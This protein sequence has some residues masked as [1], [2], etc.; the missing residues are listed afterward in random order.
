MPDEKKKAYGGMAV[1]EGV[2][3]R[4]PNHYSVACRTPNGKIFVR[5]EPIEKTWIGRQKWLLKPFLRGTFAL[6]DTMGLG[7]R[8]MRIAGDVQLDPRFQPEEGEMVHPERHKD[9]P[10]SRLQ[11]FYE[12]NQAVCDKAILGFTLVFSLVI[13]FLIF[14]VFP[15]FAG[16]Y[17]AALGKSMGIEP[18]G[19]ERGMFTT[20]LVET[21]KLVMFIG[22]VALIRRYPAIYEVFRFHGAEHQAINAM[23]EGVDLTPGNC[24]RQSRLHPR[25][26][27]NF[28]LIVFIVSFLLFPFVPRD[29]IVPG[30]SPSWL[31]AL[32][33][34]P[35]ELALLPIV[36]GI[37]YEVIRIAGKFKNE[38]WVN[39]VLWPG[40]KTQL[41]TTAEPDE[42]HA[43]VA[44]AALEAA[45]LAEEKGELTNS[46]DYVPACLRGSEEPGAP[47]DQVDRAAEKADLAHEA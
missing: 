42:R 3:M 6:L 41:I 46:D 23:E 19:N 10:P 12:R 4:S 32:T 18:A 45:V 43:E 8:A 9:K 31:I 44:I 25:C 29:L 30:D 35:V 37:S 14:N 47:H 15:N 1:V 21:I 2:M 39:V 16:Q 27:T 36:A 11:E 40:L 22:Y 17:I 28:A 34:L 20:V 26:G 13:G 33:R 5:T 24:L 7:M 38:R